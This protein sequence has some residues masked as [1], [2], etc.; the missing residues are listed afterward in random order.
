MAVVPPPSTSPSSDEKVGT[1]SKA[2]SNEERKLTET[3]KGE[4]AAASDIEAQHSSSFSIDKEKNSTEEEDPY[5]VNW[6][7]DDDP[8]NP[9]NYSSKI[10]VLTIAMV[11]SLAFL[12]YPLIH[13]GANVLDQLRPPCFR[14][15]FLKSWLTLESHQMC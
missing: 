11:A 8:L 10:K 1:L 5:L 14:L 4:L 13:V 2:A 15:R 7:G 6:T 12:T 9:L 3:E